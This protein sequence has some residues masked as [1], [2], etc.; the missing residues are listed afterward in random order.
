MLHYKHGVYSAQYISDI[1]VYF[2]SQYSFYLN[3]SSFGVYYII[4]LHA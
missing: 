1:C 4:Y 3:Y 2:A